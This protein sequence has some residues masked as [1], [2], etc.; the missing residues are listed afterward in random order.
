MQKGVPFNWNTNCENA[1]INLTTQMS[2]APILSFPHCDSNADNFSLY[3]DASSVG[4]G[5]VL[6][7]S[8]KVIAYASRSLAQAERQNSTIVFLLFMLL[9]SFVITSW[10]A[11]LTCS[12]T[13]NYSNG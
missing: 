9:S 4:V 1:F 11:I 2:M 12:Q 5:G 3:T 8:G 10:A 7:Q 6:E 13:T